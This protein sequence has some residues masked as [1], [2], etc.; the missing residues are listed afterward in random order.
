MKRAIVVLM[1][2]AGLPLAAQTGLTFRVKLLSPVD[3]ETSKQG[4]KLTAQ[5]LEPAQ[6]AGDIVEGKVTNAHGAAPATLNIEFVLI[7]HRDRQLG[8]EAW[9]LS[10]VNAQGMPG[11]DDENH[12]V[13]RIR[14]GFNIRAEIARGTDLPRGDGPTHGIGLSRG[15]GLSHG[16]WLQAAELKDI[17]LYALE[18]GREASRIH[19]VAGSEFLLSVGRLE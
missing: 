13:G 9:I 14:S 2:W 18:R 7:H 19:F 5:V 10:V 11:V 8:M 4:D 3:T 1:V 16:A 15:I 12:K 17:P 6:Y